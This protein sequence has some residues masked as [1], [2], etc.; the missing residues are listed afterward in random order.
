MSI[1]STP[2]VTFSFRNCL[3][4]PWSGH[5]ALVLHQKHLE[6]NTQ[7]TNTSLLGSIWKSQTT[8]SATCKKSKATLNFYHPL[9]H[10]S[11]HKPILYLCLDIFLLSLLWHPPTFHFHNCVYAWIPTDNLNSYEIDLFLSRRPYFF[12]FLFHHNIFNSSL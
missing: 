2:S 4:L 8:L 12:Y 9:L 7:I 10:S 5:V 3:Q 6:G 11:L 1:I